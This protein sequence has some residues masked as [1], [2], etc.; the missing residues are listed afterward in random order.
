MPPTNV[1]IS[2][3]VVKMPPTNVV[4]LGKIS[5]TYVVILHLWE[6]CDYFVG[7]SFGHILW[8]KIATFVS[9]MEYTLSHHISNRTFAEIKCMDVK[10][11]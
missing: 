9:V 3:N 10:R 5:P 4:I 1:V 11:A 2:T 7:S 6:K 8:E